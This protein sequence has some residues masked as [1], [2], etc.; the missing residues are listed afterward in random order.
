MKK[1]ITVDEAGEQLLSFIES[2]EFLDALYDF[3]M[4][5]CDKQIQK[6]EKENTIV[7]YN[8]EPYCEEDDIMWYDEHRANFLQDIFQRLNTRKPQFNL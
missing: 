2:P 6:I 4:D 1:R 7:G 8:G 3:S 5:M